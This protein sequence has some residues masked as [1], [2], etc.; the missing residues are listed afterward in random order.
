MLSTGTL[1]TTLCAHRSVVSICIFRRL[2]PSAFE[3]PPRG[4]GNSSMEEG[5]GRRGEERGGEGVGEFGHNLSWQS[6]SSSPRLYAEVKAPSS[7]QTNS[8]WSCWA[9]ADS[10]CQRYATVFLR[11]DA[12]F[13]GNEC[14]RR[15][16]NRLTLVCVE[17]FP[18]CT[19]RNPHSDDRPSTSLNLSMPFEYQGRL[20]KLPLKILTFFSTDAVSPRSTA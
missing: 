13:S 8:H 2:P 20:W 16:F 9:L 3:T 11:V 18:M 7:A 15:L 6:R 4:G 12:I 1:F 19:A 14:G 5:E 10:P 17:N